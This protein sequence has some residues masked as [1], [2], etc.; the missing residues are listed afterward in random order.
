MIRA[1]AAMFLGLN[2]DDLG[3]RYLFAFGRKINL[4]IPIRIQ[5]APFSAQPAPA[6]AGGV[7]DSEYV[8]VH[9]RRLLLAFA[10]SS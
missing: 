8:N 2:L 1:S 3:P 4:V 6:E 9:L 7:G 10:V 5:A